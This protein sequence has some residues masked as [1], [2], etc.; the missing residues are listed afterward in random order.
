MG[1]ATSVTPGRVKN[2]W[3]SSYVV[4]A[5]ASK[6]QIS[7]W[8]LTLVEWTMPFSWNQKLR[9]AGVGAG[10]PD[11]TKPAR[12]VLPIDA[13]SDKSKTALWR[14]N[15]T[16]TVLAQRMAAKGNLKWNGRM[17]WVV[18]KVL[19]NA[20]QSPSISTAHWKL[21]RTPWLPTA[22][23]NSHILQKHMNSSFQLQNENWFLR[24][25]HYIV[26]GVRNTQALPSCVLKARPVTSPWC[27]LR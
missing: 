26:I 18:T 12:L 14:K 6:R 4:T 10:D 1:P 22:D 17:E 19:K 8:T 13:G 3:P 11:T 21:T 9:P 15:T 16:I 23:W 20:E 27:V 24:M 25:W 7:S 2:S 5:T